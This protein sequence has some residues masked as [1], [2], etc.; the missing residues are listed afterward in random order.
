MPYENTAGLG[1]NNQYGVRNTGGSFGKVDDDVI[2]FLAIDFTAES[3]AG[4]FV[5][6]IV[7]PKGAHF[8]RY[9][10]R[11]DEAFTLTGTSPTVIFGGTAPA[12]DGVVLTQAE[13]AAVGTKVPASAGTGTWS[14]TSATGPLTAQTVTKALGGTTPAVTQGAGKATLIAEY[15]FK[16]KV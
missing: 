1:V 12:T 16:T 15:L 4:T 8:L 5:P 3:L 9:I 7:L 6:K 13:L 11:V 14:T 2:S 10:L